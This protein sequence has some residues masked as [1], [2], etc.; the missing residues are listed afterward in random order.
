[1]PP[2]MPIEFVANSTAEAIRGAISMGVQHKAPSFVVPPRPQ[3]DPPSLEGPPAKHAKPKT[4]D[5]TPVPKPCDQ[6]A[7]SSVASSSAATP[8]R[9]AIYGQHPEDSEYNV[10]EKEGY[11]SLI[12]FA[13]ACWG[14]NS[15]KVV[16]FLNP[17]KPIDR[18]SILTK[19]KAWNKWTAYKTKG[20]MPT[21]PRKSRSRGKRVAWADVS[22]V[23][24]ASP[25]PSPAEAGSVCLRM[26]V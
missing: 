3:R 9:P 2:P 1:M 19:Y 18:L 22:V 26:C 17:E 10:G 23:A 14:E 21:P 11:D 4:A 12:R 8:K 20:V 5:S 7:P 15:P 13:K 25:S 24:S 16:E 6:A